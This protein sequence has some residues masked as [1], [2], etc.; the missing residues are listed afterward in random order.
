M[1]IFYCPQ[2]NKKYFIEGDKLEIENEFCCD[3][4]G[5]SNQTRQTSPSSIIEKSTPTYMT[6]YEIQYEQLKT[7]RNIE[8]MIKL[9]YYTCLI[10]IGMYA[11]LL[12]IKI[13]DVL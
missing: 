12:L 4:C 1:A 10:G 2:C 7:L 9:F 6:E 8:R 13:G 3:M 5:Y 11:L